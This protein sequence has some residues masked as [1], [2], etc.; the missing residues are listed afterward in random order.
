MGNENE[1]RNGNLTN[2]GRNKALA[3]AEIA[4]L[5]AILCIALLGNLMVIVILLYRKRKLNRMQMFIIHLAVAD[6]TVALFQVLP[7]L[8]MDITFK[9]D[10]NNFLC[11][12]K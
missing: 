11:K 2:T 8:V 3:Q 4:V 6:I 7:Q 9:S 5:G 12:R 10:G 1:T